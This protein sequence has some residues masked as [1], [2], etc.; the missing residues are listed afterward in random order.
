MKFKAQTTAKEVSLLMRKH[1]CGFFLII[2]DSSK[3]KQPF[4]IEDV[5]FLG[6]EL[7]ELSHLISE[8]S[9]RI[10]C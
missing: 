5:S 10:S 6:H 3:S 4:L 7:N 8:L 2:V 1:V 9:S